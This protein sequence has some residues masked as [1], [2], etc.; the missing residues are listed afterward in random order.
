MTDHRSAQR[1]RVESARLRNRIGPHVASVTWRHG[2]FVHWPVDPARL[3]AL[4]PDPLTLETYDGY[5][6]IGVLPFVF[7]NAGLRGTPSLLRTA[8]AELN[9]RTYVRWRGDPGVYFLRIELGKPWL[10]ATLGRTTRM[11]I[12]PARMTVGAGEDRVGFVSRGPARPGVGVGTNG[13]D[14]PPDVPAHFAITYEATG[15][16]SR[17]EPGSLAHWLVERRR[18][19]APSSESMLVGEV[20]HDPWPLQPATATIHE[21]ALFEIE[22]LPRPEGEPIVHYCDDLEMTAAIPRRV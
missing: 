18:F 1:R 15:E 9:V 10:A 7:V 12:E 14:S 19:F 6:W 11:P 13:A 5:A 2:A 3:E 20:S 21:N 4:V 22:T 17:P 16:P 8:F